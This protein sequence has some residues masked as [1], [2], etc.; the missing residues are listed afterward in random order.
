MRR[1]ARAVKLAIVKLVYSSY[2]N[3]GGLL[4]SDTIYFEQMIGQISHNLI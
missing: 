3:Q 2:Q 4:K 1:L